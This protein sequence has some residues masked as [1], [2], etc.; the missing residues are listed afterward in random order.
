MKVAKTR[1]LNQCPPVLLHDKQALVA[2]DE[3][4][5]AIDIDDSAH[6]TLFI[7]WDFTGEALQVERFATCPDSWQPHMVCGEPLVLD[8]NKSDYV[9]YLPGRY[10]LST[11]SGNP[12]P[13]GFKFE[14]IKVNDR[15]VELYLAEKR[16]CC[17]E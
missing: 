15:T 12:I 13:D 7:G 5:I 9:F 10:R 1:I 8:Q 3:M 11:L 16:A 6:S 2:P 4:E 14:K 17:C